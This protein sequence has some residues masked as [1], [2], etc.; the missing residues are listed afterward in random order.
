MPHGKSLVIVESP[1]KARTISKF[2][3]RDFVVESSFGHIR[4][5]PEKKI[6]VDIAH[7][8]EPEYVTPAKAK[9]RV[10]ELKKA[11]EKADR[12]I[13]ATDE[14]REGE[15]IAW[16][17]QHALKLKDDKYDRIVFHEITPGAIKHALEHPRKIDLSLVD[18]QQARRVLDRLVGYKLSPLLWSKIRRGLS[19]GRVQSAA[20]RLIVEREREIQA[21]KSQE[22]W[23]VSAE[24]SKKD[25]D[26]KFLAKLNKIDEKSIDKLEIKNEQEAKSIVTALD[27]AGASSSAGSAP[28]W[29]VEKIETKEVKRNPAAPF[30]TSTLQQEAN[31]KLGFSGAQTMR[32]AQQLYEGL[33]VGE[34]GHTGLI[35]YMRTDSVNLSETALSEAREVIENLYGKKYV[36]SEAR[37]FTKKSKGAQ[38]AHEAIRPTSLARKPEDIKEHLDG[39]QFKL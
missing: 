30:I 23:S 21:F 31:R 37:K 20:L 2:L 6:G 22:Y 34:H 24:L 33:E 12:V 27:S 32:L 9:K 4:D 15:A 39:Q 36:L 11:A 19:A 10:T 35:T 38:E 18:A 8:F 26:K 17:L 14:D 5:L 1:T 28:K 13:L 25:D 29:Q 7:D 3:G 16:H